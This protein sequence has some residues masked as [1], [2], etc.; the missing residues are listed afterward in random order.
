MF[1]GINEVAILDGVGRGDGVGIAENIRIARSGPEVCIGNIP[2]GVPELDNINRGR[3]CPRQLRGLRI[4]VEE[5]GRQLRNLGR[6][7]GGCTARGGA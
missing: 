7:K 1:A 4:R 2:K 3:R 6:G 5:R